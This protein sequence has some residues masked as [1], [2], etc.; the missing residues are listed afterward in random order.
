M[1]SR[2]TSPA[3]Q[4]QLNGAGFFRACQRRHYRG[5][6]R[7]VRAEQHRDLDRRVRALRA[8]RRHGLR[9]H[10]GRPRRRPGPTR[11][12]DWQPGSRHFVAGNSSETFK[13]GAA[14]SILDFSQLTCPTRARV[15]S[16]ATRRADPLASPSVSKFNAGSSTVRRSLRRMSTTTRR[17][18]LSS[19]RSTATRPFPPT[20]MPLPVPIRT[21]SRAT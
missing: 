12:R 7:R 5:E 1:K 9:D 3:I 20:S 17:V 19:P 16:S 4:L 2:E 10:P 15:R 21:P 11:V 18:R 13:A 14:G 6:S 8:G